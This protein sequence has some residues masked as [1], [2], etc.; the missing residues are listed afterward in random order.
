MKRKRPADPIA[1]KFLEKY[2][3]SREVVFVAD[4]ATWRAVVKAQF[5]RARIVTTREGRR[6]VHR[7]YART[8]WSGRVKVGVFGA[9]SGHGYLASVSTALQLHGK[10]VTVAA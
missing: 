3:D 1:R 10:N 5:P 9:M 4:L 7:A 6:Q 8:R 2:F